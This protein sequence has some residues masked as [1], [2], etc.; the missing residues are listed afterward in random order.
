MGYNPPNIHYF[1]DKD[2]AKYKV[3]LD[4]VNNEKIKQ[5][6]MNLDIKSPILL[7]DP[8]KWTEQDNETIKNAILEKGGENSLDCAENLVKKEGKCVQ[9]KSSLDIDIGI[10]EISWP[11][12]SSFYQPVVDWWKDILDW[13]NNE[14][15]FQ[16]NTKP[17]KNMIEICIPICFL[18][19]CLCICICI[20]KYSS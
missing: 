16:T 17:K 9:K 13:F 19:I 12:L 14:E 20:L 1:L 6:A 8:S 2:K 10:P 3:Q 15:G 7:K 4:S 11:D 5:Q 18:L